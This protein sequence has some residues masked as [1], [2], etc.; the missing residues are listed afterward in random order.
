MREQ[1]NQWK[2]KF[3]RFYQFAEEEAQ[4]YFN[5][6]ETDFWINEQRKRG[7][8]ENHNSYSDLYQPTNCEKYDPG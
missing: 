6:R 1:F 4:S 3:N 5:Y 2:I 7:N 8:D